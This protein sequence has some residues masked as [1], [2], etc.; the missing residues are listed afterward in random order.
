MLFDPAL[1]PELL[2]DVQA[3]GGGGFGGG[4][5]SG[6]GGG[7][8][9]DGIVWVLFQLLRLAFVYPLIGVPLLILAGIVAVIGT[10]RGWWKHQ[11]HVIRRDAP[12][13]RA[14]SSHQA[15]HT[16]QHSDTGFD[17]GRF[18]SR[19]ARAFERAQSAWCAQ[20]LEPLRPFVS[21]GVFERFSLQIEEQIA[22]GWRQ[23][24]STLR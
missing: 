3:G 11:E 22:D 1:L 21:D 13:R 2:A 14:Q 6:G 18:L 20:E 5:S 9:G 24:M 12:L 8:G 23:S 4:R 7:G 17:E 10:Q 15:A 16:L 19:V